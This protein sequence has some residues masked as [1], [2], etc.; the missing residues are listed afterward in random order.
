MSDQVPRDDETVSAGGTDP[1][2]GVPGSTLI[3]QPDALGATLTDGT[4]SPGAAGRAIEAGET[5][6]GPTDLGATAFGS[7]AGSAPAKRTVPAIPGYEIECELGRGGMGVVYKARTLRLNRPVALK[8]IL[9][10]AHADAVA[11]VRFLAE[12][13]AVAQLRHPNIVQIHHI[14]EADGLPFL[15][16]E[17]VEG[18]SLDRRLDGTPW[19]ARRAAELVEAL[20]RGVAEAHR[21]G[22]VHR[23]IK[24]GN[25]LLSADDVPKVTDFGLAKAVA[26]GSGLTATG[27]I[28][29]TPSYMAPEQAQ[30][31]A[32][33]AGPAADVYALGAILYELLT[34]RPPFRGT[35]VLETLEQVKTAE[36]VPPSRLVPK[37]PRDAETIALKCLQKDPAKR[38][39]SAE[40]LG[41]DLRRFMD[42]RPIRARR[43]SATERLLRWGRRNK[44]VAGL[45][46]SLL[47][48]LVA[49]FVVSTTQWVRAERHAAREAALREQARRDLYTSDMLAVQQA[50]D[51]GT[52]GR[53]GVLLGR[54]RPPPGRPDLR[55]FEWDVFW[56]R[57]Q[58]ARPSR[59]LPLTGTVWDLA[60]TPGGQTMAAFIRDHETGLAQVTL[61]DAAT[62]WV[63]RTF[64][65]PQGGRVGTFIDSLALSPDGRLFATRSRFDREG[66]EGSFINLWDAATGEVRQSLKNPE[67]AT[68]NAWGLAFSHDGK[69]LVSGHLNRTIRLWDLGTGQARTI[70]ESGGPAF[71][72][73]DVAISHDGTRVASVSTDKRV[74]LWDVQAG[75][76]M[77]TF[78]RFSEGIA[79]SV[80]FSPD[81]RHLAAGS[82]G[83]AALWD[84]STWEARELR[85]QSGAAARSVAFSPDGSVLAASSTNTIKLWRVETGEPWA[86]VKGHSNVVFEVAFLEGGRTLAS[87]SQDQM[88]N[89][90]DLTRVGGEPEILTGNAGRG[91]GS[92]AFSP[93]GRSLASVSRNTVTSWDVDTGREHPPLEAPAEAPPG[94]IDIAISPDGRTLAAACLET[95][96]AVLW[97]LETR[98][99]R[100]RIPHEAVAS[101]AFSPREAILATGS[102]DLADPLKLWNADTGQPL[103]AFKGPQF[104]G[105]HWPA[106]SPDGRIAVLPG[107]TAQVS[108]VAISRDGRTLASGSWDGMVR[109]WDVADVDHPALRH[110][111][112]GHAAM[113]WSVALSPDGTTLASAGAD[114][115]VKLWDPAIGRERCTL[116]GHDHPVYAV[117]FSPD[118]RILASRDG[119]GTIRLWRR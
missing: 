113:V 90:W 48:T 87:A 36:P 95:N 77:H 73:K 107:H 42:D 100:Y 106:F 41:E 96:Q 59:S 34:G 80:A 37:L 1:E 76:V 38:Y 50:W 51:A 104:H 84:L 81:G 29:G 82:W 109:V 16:L 65:G 62:G 66:R 54:H 33:Q 27:S 2:A 97:D 99:I 56:R 19:P 43:V 20:A 69:T 67:D 55:G 17:Y 12:A 4:A 105:D 98:R 119:G 14:G 101:V 70:E 79:I 53:M 49:G 26:A 89:L 68:A 61:W 30:G 102:L 11:A 112:V 3:G 31:H 5:A 6:A 91:R 18:G 83:G 115:T 8:M 57:Y 116:L 85:G 25:V 111:L 110:T 92:L 40:A 72:M 60:A 58:G 93:D 118:G 32:R 7:D 117:A 24:P 46:A 88:V 63:P 10:G 94:I 74:R 64:R 114:G 75:R 45:L 21:L 71:D 35:T 9:A 52:I 108:T 103:P 15:E 13:K 28:L 39:A 86:T 47:V 78:P 44:L 23:D 22:I